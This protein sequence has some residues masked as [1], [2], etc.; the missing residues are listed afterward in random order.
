M[1]RGGDFPGCAAR[2]F[3]EVAEHAEVAESRVVRLTGEHTF[4]LRV[5]GALRDL[6]DKAGLAASMNPSMVR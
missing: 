3:T 5:L 4:L 1:P 6:R 2:L